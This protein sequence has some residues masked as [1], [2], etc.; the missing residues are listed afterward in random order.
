MRYQLSL[1]NRLGFLQAPDSTE[2]EE[3]NIEAEKVLNGLIK[4]LRNN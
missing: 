4:S 2:L 1:A 3:K